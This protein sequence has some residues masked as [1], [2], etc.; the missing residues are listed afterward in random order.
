MMKI[1]EVATLSGVSIRML[2]HYDEIGLLS[3]DDY[4]EGGYRLYGNRSLKKLQDILFFKALGF[5]LA[6]IKELMSSPNYEREAAYKQHLLTL[7][8]EK[9]KI[10]KMI[11]LVERELGIGENMETTKESM[12]AGLETEANLKELKDV[13]S[14]VK[15]HQ[16]KY[17][18]EAKER[19]GDMDKYKES[20]M[21]T[22]KYKKEDWE[23][24]KAEESANYTSFFALI[25][26]N[27]A[28][29]AVQELC[30][31]KL[32]IF[33]RYY[34][35][36]DRKFMGELSKMWLQDTRFQKNIDKYGEGLTEFMV[37]AFDVFANKKV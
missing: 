27:P 31:E 35:T 5:E 21:K 15:E 23:K 20:M 25:G 2:R 32:D 7:H 30:Q 26:S 8:K 9:S 13:M 3:P 29:K 1:K 37:A 18:D 28:D 17:A 12:Y 11:R 4:S 6:K 33:N 14:E 10:E 22:S 36:C 19:W 34:Y 24:I 16:E